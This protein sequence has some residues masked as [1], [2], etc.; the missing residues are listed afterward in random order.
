MVISAVSRIRDTAVV[1]AVYTDSR[2]NHRVHTT[3]ILETW[4]VNS[5][6]TTAL[7]NARQ[8]IL[9]TSSSNLWTWWLDLQLAGRWKLQVGDDWQL[10][11]MSAV[12]RCTVER[13][14]RL[15]HSMFL[16]LIYSMLIWSIHM[17]AERLNIYELLLV[18]QFRP[19]SVRILMSIG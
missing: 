12:W 18:Q 2:H 16:W 17:Y 8:I 3:F 6:Q 7:E 14:R 4:L 15:I 1:S 11:R 19:S 5:D 10:H 9:M 13:E